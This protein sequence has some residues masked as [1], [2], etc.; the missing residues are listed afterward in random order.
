MDQQHAV[1]KFANEVEILLDQKH[2]YAAL[3]P[4]I[5]NAFSNGCDDRWLNPF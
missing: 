3:P 1:R 4:G 5:V 2:G